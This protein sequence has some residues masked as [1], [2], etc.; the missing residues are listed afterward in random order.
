M[1]S[2]TIRQNKEGYY[3]KE[4]FKRL[5]TN[6]EFCG[7][8]VKVVAVTSC[9]PNEGKS[10]C[11]FNLAR[12]LSESGHKV[13]LLDADIRKSM[14]ARRF[15]TDEQIKGLTHF[16]AGMEPLQEVLYKT[17]EKNFYVVFSGPSV[18]NPVD[19]LSS[20]KFEKLLSSCRALF[21]Y[22]IID[23]PPLASVIDAAIISKNCDGSLM[24]ISQGSINYRIA[25]SVKDQLEKTGCKI[26]GV[27]MNNV[28][29]HSGG[30]YG[31]YYK[32]YYGNGYYEHT[33]DDA[34]ENE[35]DE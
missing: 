17:D 21:D 13:L 31:G 26:L 12:S 1:K 23:C 27:V 11:S 35:T 24:V 8:D 3:T 4:A 29:I 33:D 32:K 14:M 30:Y 2:I 22:I 10:K 25:Q 9:T 6:I 5:H 20:D 19:L 28:D 18:P 16:L 34:S 15:E 7:D